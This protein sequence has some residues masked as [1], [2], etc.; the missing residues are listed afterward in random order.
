MNYQDM[1][2]IKKGDEIKYLDKHNGGFKVGIVTGSN[3]GAQPS[4]DISQKEGH[5]ISVHTGTNFTEA[6]WYK[7]GNHRY[8]KFADQE[9]EDASMEWIRGL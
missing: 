2:A 6:A 4:L 3:G 5:S 9:R 7:F 8:F 1:L